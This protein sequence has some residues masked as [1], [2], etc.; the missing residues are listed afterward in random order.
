MTSLNEN[1]TQPDCQICL[2]A[3]AQKIDTSLFNC[4]C[5]FYAHLR[6]FAKFINS[7]QRLKTYIDCPICHNRVNLLESTAIIAAYFAEVQG[8]Y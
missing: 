1:N 2:E 6:C 4:H 7:Q 8:C 5:T 3:N